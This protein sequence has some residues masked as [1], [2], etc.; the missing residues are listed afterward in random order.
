M[1]LH[2]KFPGFVFLSGN[3]GDDAQHDR[4]KRVLSAVREFER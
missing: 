3:D 4:E 2:P 1:F